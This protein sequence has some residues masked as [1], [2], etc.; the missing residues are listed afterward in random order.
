MQSAIQGNETVIIIRFNTEQDRVRGVATL[1]RSF[2]WFKAL[3]KN[4]FLVKMKEL[5][6]FE[7]KN[8]KYSKIK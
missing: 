1:M 6:L 5:E 3:G 4:Q 2:E 8:I 7:S